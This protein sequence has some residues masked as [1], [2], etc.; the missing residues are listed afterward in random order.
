MAANVPLG[1]DPLGP[2]CQNHQDCSLG[3]GTA[4]EPGPERSHRHFHPLLCLDPV[5]SNFPASL[6][7]YGITRT[8]VNEA[9]SESMV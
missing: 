2:L 3:R 9:G 1:H 5:H 4:A 8:L 6:L 7:H